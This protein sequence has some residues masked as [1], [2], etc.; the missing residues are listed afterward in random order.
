MA[1]P[2]TQRNTRANTQRN[3][4][5]RQVLSRLDTG[6]LVREAR[7]IAGLSQSELAARVGTTQ[8]AVSN[9]ERGRDVPR[10]DTLGRILQACGFEVDLTFR[11][12]DDV[13]RS[14]IVQML[15][16]TPDQRI[17]QVENIAALLGLAALA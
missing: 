6:A 17:E 5:D 10:V 16:A 4:P 8:S 2:S 14:Q 3:R 12:H 15:E 13:D 1:S 9:W 7:R 11:R